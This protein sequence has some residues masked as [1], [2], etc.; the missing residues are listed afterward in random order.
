MP[1]KIPPTPKMNIAKAGKTAGQEKLLA[2]KKPIFLRSLS[3]VLL[4]RTE[5]RVLLCGSLV[6]TVAELGR[7][8][9][10]L[11]LDLLQ[12][13]ARGVG[14]HRLAE[15]HDALLDSRDGT[16]E[17]DEV[18]LDLSVADEATHAK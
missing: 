15:S 9:D 1:G 5:E 7:R 3:S 12:G 2:N 17:D 10:P 13:L 11:Q 14:V 8:V 16:L 4:E 18:V 6:S